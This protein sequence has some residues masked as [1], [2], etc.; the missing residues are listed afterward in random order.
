MNNFKK[1]NPSPFS[2]TYNSQWRN[3]PNFSWKNGNQAQQAQQPQAQPNAQHPQA[4]KP[5]NYPPYQN[6]QVKPLEETL[7]TFM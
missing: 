1:P 5:F 2:E 4:Q 6:P 7:R 3:H